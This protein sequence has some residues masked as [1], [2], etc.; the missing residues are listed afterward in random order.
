MRKIAPDGTLIRR[1]L[2]G[3]PMN[4]PVG[5][6]YGADSGLYIGNFTDRKIHLWKFDSLKYIAT[7]PGPLNTSLGFITEAHG[8]LY[9]TT[10]QSNQVYEINPNYLDSTRL[11]AGSSAGNT[12]GPVAVAKFNRP[13]GIYASRGGDSLL[14]SDFT[15]GNIRMITGLTTGIIQEKLIEL[16]TMLYPNPSKEAF[17]I[18]S[19]EVILSIKIYSILGKLVFQKQHI[20]AKSFKVEA[21]L[22]KGN[23]IL[24]LITAKGIQNKKFI[25]N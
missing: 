12:D 3:F 24:T 6:V 21:L 20:S 5:L 2:F 8:L 13:N 19:D 4:G 9:G 10:F 25:V 18:K 15:T 23:Y 14:I 11:L 1:F 7:V 17:N 16:N 22:P